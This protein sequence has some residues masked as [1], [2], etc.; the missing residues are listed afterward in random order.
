MLLPALIFLATAN[1]KVSFRL[2]L[3]T[4]AR[5]PEMPKAALIQDRQKAYSYVLLVKKGQPRPWAMMKTNWRRTNYVA[6][7]PGLV[8]VDAK[9]MIKSIT[10]DKKG[11]TV[12]I[13]TRPGI[14]AMTHYP[15]FFVTI[16]KQ[17]QKLP[18][19][20]DDPDRF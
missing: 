3:K 2:L 9:V 6:I 7:Y 10:H 14:S 1:Q 16:P 4:E 17:L 8:Q 5:S 11:L 18:A 12:R 13:E 20:L 15:I 19:T